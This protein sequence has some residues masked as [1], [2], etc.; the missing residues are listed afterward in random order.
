MSPLAIVL[1]VVAAV[2]LL[3]FVGGYAATRRRERARALDYARHVAAADR[4]LETARAA[5]RG[6]DRERLDSAARRALRTERP[7]FEPE[8]LDLVLVDDRP[9]VAED[10]AHLVAS[11]REGEV[12]IVLCR[13][14][15]DW[16]LEHLR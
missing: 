2:L 16:A 4:A 3:L 11:G 10:R 8:R 12:T 7:G 5:D 6:W 14:D 15:G 9:G 13:R 1:V